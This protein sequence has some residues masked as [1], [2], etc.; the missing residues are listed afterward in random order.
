MRSSPSFQKT[1]HHTLASYGLST[2]IPAS[3]CCWAS[4]SYAMSSWGETLQCLSH[5]GWSSCVG[6]PA[7]GSIESVWLN[8]PGCHSASARTTSHLPDIL[9]PCINNL[10]VYAGEPNNCRSFFIQYEVVFSPAQPVKSGL[11]YLTPSRASSWL[12]CCCLGFIG[13]MLWGFTWAQAQDDQCLW[14]VSLR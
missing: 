7:L 6:H 12:G 4:G 5:C 2:G 13:A 14:L 10:P 8:R 3:R 9:E 11:R 1:W